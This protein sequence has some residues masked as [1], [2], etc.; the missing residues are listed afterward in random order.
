MRR[1]CS[2]VETI[3]RICGLSR[4]LKCNSFKKAI[5]LLF[6]M[7]LF[8]EYL[9]CIRFE[10]TAVYMGSEIW[11]ENL[12]NISFNHT[13]HRSAI[14]AIRT[15]WQRSTL[16]KTTG[17]GLCSSHRNSFTFEP[18]GFLFN[19]HPIFILRNENVLVAPKS[20]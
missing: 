3:V 1:I 14:I 6:I 11:P 18:G 16:D 4:P 8:Q 12:L 15:M 10:I 13:N 19:P 5:P 20:D 9:G 17:L 7:F 2:S